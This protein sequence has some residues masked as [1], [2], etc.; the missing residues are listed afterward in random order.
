L[1][2]PVCVGCLLGLCRH[3]F[4]GR[5][6]D[7]FR[8]QDGIVVIGASY[9]RGW[10]DF[11]PGGITVINKGVNGEQSSEM[12][13]RFGRDVIDERPDAV[14]IWGFI[15]D[16]FRSSREG[17]D[18]ALERTRKNIME[19]VG[20][21]KANGIRPIVATEVTIRGRSGIRETIA[22]WI[23]R[24]KGG[25]SYQDYVNRHVLRTN[26]WIREYALEQRI[27]LLDFQPL[28]ADGGSGR[29]PEYAMG[30][31]S[32]LSPQAYRRLSQYAGEKLRQGIR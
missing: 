2:G 6:L 19:M 14:I 16:I 27:A 15:N 28:L 22:S 11:A 20:L 17:I 12:L 7:E 21:A 13:A 26:Q 30:D 3:A 25:E 18:P 31:G 4:H 1:E 24:I 9:A 32:H 23:G 10:S 8:K 5:P 29:K